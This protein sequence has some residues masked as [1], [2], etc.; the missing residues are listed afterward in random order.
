MDVPSGVMCTMQAGAGCWVYIDGAAT[1]ADSAITTSV[2]GYSWILI[3]VSLLA[4]LMIN[5]MSWGDLVQEDEPSTSSRAKLFLLLAVIMQ[6]G[7]I[8]AGAL[9]MGTVYLNKANAGVDTWG[10]I[11]IFAGNL[12]IGMACWLQRL[13]TLPSR[14]ESAGL[15]G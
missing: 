8:T 3:V 12:A 9:V 2:S 7:M 5:G 15:L 11:S 14:G 10:G 4:Y 13:S 1:G 6:I